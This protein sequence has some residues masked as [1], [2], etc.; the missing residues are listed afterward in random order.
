M[1]ACPTA[2]TT[3]K[4]KFCE[5]PA[6]EVPWVKGV[7]GVAGA[8][9]NPALG[10]VTWTGT[11][12]SAPGGNRG[13]PRL[14]NAASKPAL[15]FS[16]GWKGGQ[17]TTVNWEKK[18]TELIVKYSDADFGETIHFKTNG[19]AS[20]F[21]CI[22]VGPTDTWTPPNT[23]SGSGNDRNTDPGDFSSIKITDPNGFT[24]LVMD[25]DSNG[26]SGTNGILGLQAKPLVVAGPEGCPETTTTTTTTPACDET[27]KGRR[28]RDYEGCQTM[29]KTGRTC[30]KWNVNSPHRPKYGRSWD[31]NYCRNPDG[32]STIW[33]YTTDPRKRWEYCTPL[34]R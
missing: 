12:R 26:W 5:G 32:S 13:Q 34:T 27:L 23:L 25:H 7:G 31:H 19:G 3:A 6:T 1:K 10:R 16:N 9:F 22:L 24:S 28:D 18:I 4:P 14:G 30:Q 2:T 29:T 11:A 21:E 20:T 15:I 33:C 8:I 17:T